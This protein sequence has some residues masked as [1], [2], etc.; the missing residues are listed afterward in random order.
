MVRKIVTFTGDR[1]VIF[2]DGEENSEISIGY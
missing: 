2:D 1:N